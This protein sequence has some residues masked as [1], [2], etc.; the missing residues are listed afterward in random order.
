MMR[1]ILFLV[2]GFFLANIV[3]ATFFWHP[4]DQ[5]SGKQ[6]P[7]VNS[8]TRQGQDPWM[9]NERYLVDSRANI[10]KGMLETLSKPWADYCTPDGHK[11][12]IGAINNYYYQRNAETWSKVNTYGEQARGFA[13]R[14]WTTTDDNRIER[15]TSE[16]SDRGYFSLDE[17]QPYAR[18]PLS[19]LAT[20]GSRARPCAS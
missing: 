8:A 3:T 1:L 19:A 10:R 9:A 2:G 7:I 17:L 16:L 20:R 11:G 18:A 5:A 13:V 15:L 6:E 12:L 14:A 4:P